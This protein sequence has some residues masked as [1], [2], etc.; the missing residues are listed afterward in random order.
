[1]RGL[2]LNTTALGR[3]YHPQAG[4]TARSAA[5]LTGPVSPTSPFEVANCDF[6]FPTRPTWKRISLAN[7]PTDQPIN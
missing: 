7:R 5:R 1:M 4:E 2:R 3:I 6:K